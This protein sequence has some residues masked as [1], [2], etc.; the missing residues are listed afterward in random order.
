MGESRHYSLSTWLRG[1][2]LSLFHGCMPPP[3]QLSEADV[4]GILQPL[5]P[6]I[7]CLGHSEGWRVWGQASIWRLLVIRQASVGW[8][9]AV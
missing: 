2:F 4:E 1:E 8:V 9:G 7:V 6:D 3:S 5:V